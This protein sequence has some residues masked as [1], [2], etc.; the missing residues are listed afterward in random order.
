M[1]EWLIGVVG[2]ISLGLLLEILIP[3]GQTSKYVKGAFSLLVIFV[4]ISPLPK[5]L[6]GEYDFNFEGVSYEIDNEYLAYATKEYSSSLE[7]DLEDMLEN[8]GVLSRVEIVTKEGSVREI[9]FVMIK[10]CLSGIDE[11][12]ENTHISRTKELVSKALNISSERV[13]VSVEYG[14]G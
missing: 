1:S 14:S 7:D 10:I 13:K 8:E 11:D 9:D 2:I 6:D 4:V 12:Q 3:E 5:L